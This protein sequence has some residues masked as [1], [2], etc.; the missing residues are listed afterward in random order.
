L[1]CLL[2][3]VAGRSPLEYLDS[4]ERARQKAAVLALMADPPQTVADLTSRFLH[5]LEQA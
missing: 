4:D 2:A 5:E 1:G 3:R